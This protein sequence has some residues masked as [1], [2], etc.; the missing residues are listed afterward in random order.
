MNQEK[1]QSYATD[2]LESLN[3]IHAN[4]VIHSDLKLQNALLQRPEDE[5][6]Q[7]EFP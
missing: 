7:S 2:L 5:D 1:L 6:D 4:G 3:Y